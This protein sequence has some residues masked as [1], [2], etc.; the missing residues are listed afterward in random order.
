[1][2][3]LYPMF[4]KQKAGS[5]IAMSIGADI[6]ADVSKTS[7]DITLSSSDVN[8][9]VESTNLDVFSESLIEA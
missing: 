3:S 5:S 6:Q 2:I 1:M 8:I 4:L 9:G 7:M